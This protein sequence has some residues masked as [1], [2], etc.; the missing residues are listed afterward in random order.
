MIIF[1]CFTEKLNSYIYTNIMKNNSK[2]YIYCIFLL[3]SNNFLIY[4]ENLHKNQPS[5]FKRFSYASGL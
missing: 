1:Y 4:V 5:I 3:N 2:K